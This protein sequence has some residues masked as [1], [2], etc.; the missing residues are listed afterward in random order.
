MLVGVLGQEPPRIRFALFGHLYARRA[1]IGYRFG[2]LQV[3]L[4]T[5][6]YL[7]E[8]VTFRTPL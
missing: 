7:L 5:A 1:L 8:I 6:L 4:H 3:Q 2:K